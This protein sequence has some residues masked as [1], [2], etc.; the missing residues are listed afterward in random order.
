MPR[1]TPIGFAHRGARA[2]APEN[3]LAAFALALEMGATGL[4]T[5]AWLTADGQAVLDHDGVVDRTP[6]A[7]IER[8][9]L[10]EHIPTLAEL[11]AECGGDYELSIDIKNEAAAPEVIR[12]AQ[13]AG[14]ASRVWLCHWNWKRL[15]SWRRLSDAVRLVDSTRARSMNTPLPERALRM[16]EH[17]IDVLNLHH[18]DWQPEWVEM[19]HKSGRYAFAWGLQ[20]ERALARLVDAGV[21]AV[22]SDHVDRMM[23]VLDRGARLGEVASPRAPV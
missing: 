20:E 13:L 8:G 5:D 15:A 16:R 2:H 22:Y 11:Y 3:T 9:G 23:R 12:C 17:E 21:D 18:S 19:L 6:I 1:L 7:R 4:E 10:P 14:A